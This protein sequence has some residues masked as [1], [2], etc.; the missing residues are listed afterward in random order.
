MEALLSW[1]VRGPWGLEGGWEVLGQ[2]WLAERPAPRT[3]S[4]CLL[5]GF[6]GEALSG[7]GEGRSPDDRC[8]EMCTRTVTHRHSHL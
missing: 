7:Q 3:A 6:P 5:R 1:A 8:C 2:R 4:P